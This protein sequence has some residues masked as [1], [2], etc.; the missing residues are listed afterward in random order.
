M[1]SFFPIST[2]PDDSGASAESAS[3]PMPHDAIG[4]L[5][6]QS[7]TRLTGIFAVPLENDE[8][9]ITVMRRM[10]ADFQSVIDSGG[11]QVKKLEFSGHGAF[12]V[13]SKPARA[14]RANY[15]VFTFA[16]EDIELPLLSGERI[17]RNVSLHHAEKDVAGASVKHHV[18]AIFPK[19]Q[20][21]VPVFPDAGQ[22]KALY[23]APL[24][25]R[26][27][28]AYHTAEEARTIITS[29]KPVEALKTLERQ[30]TERNRSER[31]AA[32]VAADA[33]AK[34]LARE[35]AIKLQAAQGSTLPPE[36]V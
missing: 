22:L 20:R 1:P 17:V 27:S 36:G 34:R 23:S 32:R 15:V 13:A 14:A 7:R 31:E 3:L 30:L 18:D 2:L 19:F 26:A 21:L 8:H 12:S 9:V 6:L 28:F 11:Y 16:R 24:G 10:D 25:N 4:L 29:D 35:A 33:E 5:T